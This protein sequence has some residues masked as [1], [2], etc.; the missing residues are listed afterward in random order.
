MSAAERELLRDV[1]SRRAWRCAVEEAHVE[2]LGVAAVGAVFLHVVPL[3]FHTSL[4]DALPRKGRH[5]SE[6]EPLDW[7][8]PAAL[9]RIRILVCGWLAPGRARWAACR[10]RRIIAVTGMLGACA[11]LLVSMRTENPFWA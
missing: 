4:A 1:S 8:A 9:R 7:R 6:G 3:V 5:L 10:N 11:C 2:P